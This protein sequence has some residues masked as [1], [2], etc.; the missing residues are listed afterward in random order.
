MCAH[1]NVQSHWKDAKTLMQTMQPAVRVTDRRT[2]T[3]RLRNVTNNGN[4][5][6]M[7]TFSAVSCTAA[8]SSEQ[9]IASNFRAAA[10]PTNVNNTCH[11]KRVRP[12]TA[13]DGDRGTTPRQATGKTLCH[14]HNNNNGCETNQLCCSTH[15]VWSSE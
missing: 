12:I 8:S 6:N 1:C 3:Y 15:T 10:S 7:P 14:I 13:R 9:Q 4:R 5:L 11:A 2:V